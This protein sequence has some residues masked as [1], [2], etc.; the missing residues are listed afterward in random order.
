MHVDVPK[1]VKKYE[2]SRLQS[3]FVR[4]GRL[5]RIEEKMQ[6]SCQK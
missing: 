5:V 2:F 3:I 1:K 6:V 4:Q